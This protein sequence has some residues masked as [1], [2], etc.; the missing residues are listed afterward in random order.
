MFFLKKIIAIKGIGQADD[1]HK[2]I[3][4]SVPAPIT[5]I[6]KSSTPIQTVTTSTVTPVVVHKKKIIAPPT[7]SK[8]SS[9]T[10]S[11]ILSGLAS[12][13]GLFAS[14][15]VT[16]PVET[17]EI[18]S[19]IAPPIVHKDT[20]A[21]HST[22]EIQNARDYIDEKQ[23]LTSFSYINNNTDSRD[24]AKKDKFVAELIRLSTSRTSIPI[25]T[26]LDKIGDTYK[27]L[28]GRALPST[29]PTGKLSRNLYDA[30][31]QL[32]QLLPPSPVVTTH[33]HT[34]LPVFRTQKHKPV[35]RKTSGI[36]TKRLNIEYTLPI[37]APLRRGQ[38]LSR[39]DLLALF[40][41]VND[42]VANTAYQESPSDLIRNKDGIA[43]RPNHNGTHALRQVFNFQAY[44]DLVQTKGTPNAKTA[45][46]SISD[47]EMNVALFAMY[48][49][50]IGRTWECTHS[51]DP[52][53]TERSAKL[54]RYFAE[55]LNIE[56]ALIDFYE[57]AVDE[58]CNDN[59]RVS[60]L[61]SL[62]SKPTDQQL[63]KKLLIWHAMS[64]AHEADLFRCGNPYAKLAY[65]FERS[66][67]LSDVTQTERTK[68]CDYAKK[69]LV[70]SGDS[71]HLGQSYK[72]DIFV[73]AS[74]DMS[75][76]YSQLDAVS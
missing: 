18:A 58:F 8:S 4:R 20:T 34:P 59:Y 33:L 22:S 67:V 16:S 39:Q 13:F 19:D 48:F 61:T 14:E 55:Q 62:T 38:A 41:I 32:S 52:S 15:P 23:A 74:R 63:N 53:Y 29:R 24:K 51:S 56:P 65:H 30:Y 27:A 45:L 6:V 26:R 9:W 66:D 70:A 47:H 75:F 25:Q 71:R 57:E 73:P 60:I 68:F 72:L 11:G 21:T 5:R 43:Y 46:T 10:F 64:S 36:P 1:S 50:R 31:Q 54:F 42:S 35:L 76:C 49:S 3:K 2:L 69:L 44:L 7:P 37:L 12:G 28:M 17:I 40:Q